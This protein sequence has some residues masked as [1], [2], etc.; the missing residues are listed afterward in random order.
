MADNKTTN[1]LGV[2]IPN[3][4]YDWIITQIG[5]EKSITLSGATAPHGRARHSSIINDSI[6]LRKTKVYYPGNDSPTTIVYGIRYEDIVLKGRFS[7]AY[8]YKEALTEDGV[9]TIVEYIKAMVKDKYPITVAWGSIIAIEGTFDTVSFER[10]SPGEV[11]YTIT[12]NVD[13]DLLSYKA[14]DDDLNFS[15][16]EGEVFDAAKT[17]S[18]NMEK[19]KVEALA[20]PD[21]SIFDAI[22]KVSYALNAPIRSFVKCATQI[23]DARNQT[24]ASLNRFK[25]SIIQV[26][27]GYSILMD[28][29]EKLNNDKDNFI[30]A[31]RGY[32]EET[33][34]LL[35]IKRL[36][37]KSKK[38]KF[39]KIKMIIKALDGD[40][41]GSLSERG[42]I[43]MGH[44]EDVKNAN[45]GVDNPIEGTN[46][47]IPRLV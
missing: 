13:N 23:K 28:E 14:I 8:S 38:L 46:Y 5:G 25:S 29:Y 22:N 34:D 26:K 47:I 10:E 4:T 36:D 33:N 37:E 45:G 21:I 43:G 19:I 41:W 16:F 31:T 11:A 24:V 32:G 6:K 40:T 17:I 20:A 2:S 30:V 12:I 44:G 15:G 9:N 7:S 27:N 18:K 35:I 1:K 39:S 3:S 42:G